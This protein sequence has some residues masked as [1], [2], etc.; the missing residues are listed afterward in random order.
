SFIDGLFATH[1]PSAK[2]VQ[3]NRELVQKVGAGGYRGEDV[4]ERKMAKLR[5]LQPAYDAHD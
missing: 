2:R 1:P 5:S 4:Y 3:E